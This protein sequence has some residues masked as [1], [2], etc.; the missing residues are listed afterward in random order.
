M[1]VPFNRPKAIS[2]EIE[3][4]SDVINNRYHLSGDGYY[5]KECHRLLENK[6]GSTKALLVHSCTAAL[7]MAAILCNLKPGDEVI[8]PSFTFVSTANAVCLR[9]AVPVFVDIDEHT[10]NITSQTILPAITSKTK[11]IYV[12]HY[13]GVVCDMEPILSL[14]KQHNLY[15]VEDAAQALGSQYKGKKAGS[16]GDLAAFSFHE[17]KNIISGEGGALTINNETMIE[18]AEI[19]REKGTNRSQFFR[20]MVDKYSWVDVGSSYLPSELTAAFLC[21]QLEQEELIYKRRT[22]I[23]QQYYA[24]FNHPKVT[25]SV[26]LP[27]VPN[28]VT[29]NGHMFYLIFP[30]IESRQGFIDFCNEQHIIA[31]F[32]YIPL[33]SSSAGQKFSR[34]SGDMKV[35]NTI[36]DTL[37][38][39]PMYLF[40]D[41][42]LHYVKQKLVEYFGI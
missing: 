39:L 6:T 22:E 17:T 24:L 14:A 20:G 3:Y 30:D 4:V 40:E 29:H 31:P 1:K 11:A 26:R 18:R 41:D 32:H 36:S 9:G 2:K 42:E 33:H 37:V 38:R 5:T 12:V 16:F 8:M 34:Y 15:V 7:E 19:I 35:T 25:K 27:Y 21:A 10:L 28:D 13:A 23:W